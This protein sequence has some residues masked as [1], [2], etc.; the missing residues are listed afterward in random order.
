MVRIR[1]E[2]RLGFFRFVLGGIERILTT[3][4]LRGSAIIYDICMG[5][6][7]ESLLLEGK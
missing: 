7:G 6:P 1:E 2:S 4:A 3:F 5:P